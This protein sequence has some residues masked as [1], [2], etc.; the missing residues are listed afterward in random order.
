MA[1]LVVISA[2]FLFP[3]FW[4]ISS[5]FKSTTDMF[6]LP[7]IWI[8]HSGWEH[9]LN[10]IRS[11][12]LMTYFLHSV[13]EAGVSTVVVL[14]L[15]TMMAYS[16][17][18]HGWRRRTGLANFILSLKIMPPVAAVVPVY[19]L[20]THLKL[21]DTIQGMIIVYIMFN[22]PLATW[23]LLGFL[24]QVPVALDEAATIDGASQWQVLLRVI[25]PI[26]RASL[27]GI[28]LVCFMF[29]WNDFFFAVSLTSSHAV[30]MTVETDS[31]LGDYIY[32]WASFY[33]SG[34]LEIVPMLIIGV[35][36]QR[37][38]IRGLSLGA[39]AGA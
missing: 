12:H 23:L 6:K 15:A 38:L 25:M 36:M 2:V 5:A 17:S 16:L 26:L 37:Y 24:R 1:F 8:P 20:M 34:A 30:T 10:I 4:L 19:L 21:Y 39:L 7:P 33:V 22:L 18:R 29:A 27:V 32:Q 28:G 3:V 11:N 14:L 9:V 13:V 35:V 31:F